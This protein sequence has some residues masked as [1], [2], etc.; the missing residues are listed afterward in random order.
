MLRGAHAVRIEHDFALIELGI[1]LHVEHAERTTT[2]VFKIKQPG[3]TER[4]D[5]GAA[6]IEELAG[7]DREFH[8][9]GIEDSIAQSD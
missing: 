8:H 6:A 2:G 3:R 5:H 9:A 4:A 1:A 7:A